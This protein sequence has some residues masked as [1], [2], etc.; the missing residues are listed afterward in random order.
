MS[1]Y[2]I[3][4]LTGLIITIIVS[5]LAIW[6]NKTKNTEPP[7]L[8]CTVGRFIDKY[9]WIFLILIFAVY[10]ISRV[11]K[12]DSFPNGIHVDELSM[13]CD[14]KSILL[15][16]IE[17]SGAKYP[18][19]FRNYGGGQNS[20][21][22]YIQAFLLNFI[23][24]TIFG[25][26]I[27]AVFWGAVCMFAMFG[28]CYEILEDHG[29]AL[30]AP[31][32][33]TT[34]PVFIMSQRFALESY[35][36]L[37]FCTIVMYLLIRALKYQRSL[38]FVLTGIFMGASLYTYALC[39]IVWPLFLI[40]AGIYLLYV[41]KITFRQVVLFAVPLG[42]LAVPLILF[43]LV[44]FG[45]L[46]PFT[47]GISD[48]QP[49]PIAREEDLGFSNILWNLT[50]FKKMFLGGEPLTY[51][52]LPEFGTVYMF[53]IPFVVIGFIICVKDT[54]AA[55]K[56]RVFS[57]QPLMVFFW[58]AGTIVMLITK[59]LNINRVNELF[60]PFTVFIVIAIHRLLAKNPLALTWLAV[61]TGASFFFFM[62]FYFFI[63]NTVYGYHPIHTSAT[64]GKAI[65]RCE[66]YYRKDENTHIYIQ[67]EDIA[68][69]PAQQVF[70][71]AAQPGD[72]YSED[73]VTYGN[74]TGKLPEEIDVNENAIYIIGDQWPHITSYLISQGFIADQTLPG[75]SILFK[76]N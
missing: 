36:L 43:Q 39:Y 15:N 2:E 38:D 45:I 67:F 20:L 3:F 58:L 55:F 41:K 49:L 54:V 76:V 30:I 21:Y 12:L 46:E 16:G 35:Q 37:P 47:L 22:I 60:L 24:S 70:Y 14:A 53:L 27:Q 42:I 69:A 33:V 26:R 29:Y 52:V 32:L 13:A 44:N 1:I 64:P 71:F 62:Y 28:I 73:N 11:L 17:R 23:P 9:Y 57:I 65:E 40:L 10:V 48:Y 59:G 66:K 4:A 74:V 31:A 19:Y 50:Y 7:A 61:W 34:L 5:S 72:V 56:N 8:F 6:R 63:Q 68:E 25:F 51:N 75:Y 18:P